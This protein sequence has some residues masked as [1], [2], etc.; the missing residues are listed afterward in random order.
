M[1]RDTVSHMKTRKQVRPLRRAKGYR[2]TSL[3]LPTELLERLDRTA[4]ASQRSRSGQAVFFLTEAV[5]RFDTASHPQQEH[6][7]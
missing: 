5:S 4:K 1:G 6:A 3:V 7:A 2:T